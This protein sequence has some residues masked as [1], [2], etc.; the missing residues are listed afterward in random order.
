MTIKEMG[1]AIK[2][3]QSKISAFATGKT[4]VNAEQFEASVSDLTS[5]IESLSGEFETIKDENADLL[6]KIAELETSASTKES[7]H[8]AAIKAKEDEVA[9]A[10][11]KKAAAICASQGVAPVTAKTDEIAN[12]KT[13]TLDSI[14]E[15]IRSEK[16][17]DKRRELALKARDLR[18]H[19][20]IF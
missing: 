11:A 18:G 19:K 14:R 8:A 5:K 1:A 13:E 15:Q 7:E 2:D 3:I 10:A 9:V 17:P 4:N 20:G 16:D 12:P 6:A